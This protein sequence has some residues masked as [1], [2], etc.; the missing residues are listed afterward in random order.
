ME[1]VL[2][3][4]QILFVLAIAVVAILQ[5][6]KKAPGDRGT[7][8]AVRRRAGE[9]ERTRRIQEEIRRRIM[10]RRG[11][12]P[13]APQAGA[14]GEEPRP[15]PAAP[16]MIEEIRPVRVE[17][18]PMIEGVPAAAAAELERQRALAE[19]VRELE[20]LRTKQAA[21]TAR[22]T[23]AAASAAAV[24]A[25]PQ[26]RLLLDLRNRPELRRA[27]VLREILGPPVGLR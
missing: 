5:R 25:E 11:L 24:A 6:L 15:F 7:P 3:H 1:W 4:L 12:A 13:G 27:I 23:A 26:R 19:R 20:A 10:E 14:G 22:A 18:P 2:D 9:E 16:P 8:A 17:P 21:A